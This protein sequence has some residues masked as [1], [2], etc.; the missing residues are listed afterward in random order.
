[1]TS[2]ALSD[3]LL[4]QPFQPFTFMLGDHTEIRIERSEWVKH[5]PRPWSDRP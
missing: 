4:R 2:A 3:L 1:M 5:K